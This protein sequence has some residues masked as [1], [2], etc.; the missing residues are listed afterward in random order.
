MKSARESVAQDSSI[1]NKTQALNDTY[2]LTGELAFTQE[3]IEKMVSDGTYQGLLSGSKSAADGVSQNILDKLGSKNEN[4]IFEPNV[5]KISQY[6]KELNQMLGL[7]GKNQMSA[8]D[9]ADN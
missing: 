1:N 2:N 4:G 7:T 5:K 8:K 3:E 6:N 9:L